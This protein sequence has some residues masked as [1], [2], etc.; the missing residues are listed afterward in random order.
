[1]FSSGLHPLGRNCPGLVVEIN[2]A[3]SRSKNFVCSRSR[4]DE[5][6]ERESHALSQPA[7]SQSVDEFRNLVVG[8][9]GMVIAA[10]RLSRQPLGNGTNRILT[11]S[12]PGGRGPIQHRA[13]ALTYASGSLRLRQPDRGQDLKDLWRPDLI[14]FAR[15]HHRKSVCGQGHDP[16]SGMLFVLP[17]SSVGL[18][19][20]DRCLFKRRHERA[21]PCASPITGRRPRGLA[22]YIAQP[23]HAPQRGRPA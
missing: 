5:K 22:S 13:N 9:C 7:V 4:Q 1:M 14:D 19:D 3:P 10:I 8:H 12:E 15:T 23:S 2:L 21:K 18:M 16:L 20:R 17:R 6:L 11:G